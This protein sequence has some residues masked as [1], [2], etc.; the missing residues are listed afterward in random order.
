[1][2]ILQIMYYVHKL[3]TLTA[4]KQS[5]THFKASSA[6]PSSTETRRKCCENS[7]ASNRVLINFQP[8]PFA[9]TTSP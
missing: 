6:P 5:T 1:M 2:V 9:Y 4:P 8:H 7:P 3:M